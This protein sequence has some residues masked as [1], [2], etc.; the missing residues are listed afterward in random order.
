M[1]HRSGLSQAGNSFREQFLEQLIGEDNF[2][3]VID[4]FVNSLDLASLG[5]SH[6]ELNNTGRPPYSPYLMMNSANSSALF[7]TL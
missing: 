5:L 2:V 3:R 7:F 1:H 4:A 6:V